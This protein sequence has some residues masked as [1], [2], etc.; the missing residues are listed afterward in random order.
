MRHGVPRAMPPPM[1][2]LTFL[3]CTPIAVDKPADTA[4]DSGLVA[5]SSDSAGAGDS[6][7]PDTGAKIHG[8]WAAD[9]LPAPEFVATNRDEAPRG[10]AD[11]IGHPTVVWFYPAA[12]T[13]G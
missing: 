5:D 6:N 2:I 3:A 9:R 11:L 7:E 1:T 8:E 13:A 12:T 4:V 10:Q